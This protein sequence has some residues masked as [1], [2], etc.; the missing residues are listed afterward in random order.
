MTEE[1]TPGERDLEELEERT[2]RLTADIAQAKEDLVDPGDDSRLDQ[3]VEGAVGDR[4]QSA[5]DEP[6]AEGAPKG[7]A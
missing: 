6:E 3:N 2:E 4:P 1:E 7:W 5:D